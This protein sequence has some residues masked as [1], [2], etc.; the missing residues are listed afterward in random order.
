MYVGTC[1]GFRLGSLVGCG[2]MSSFDPAVP[3]LAVDLRELDRGAPPA[4]PWYQ[5]GVIHD[6]DRQLQVVTDSALHVAFIPVSGGYVFYHSGRGP[7]YPNGTARSELIDHDGRP[8]REL[9]GIPSVSTAGATLAWNEARGTDGVVF[10]VDAISGEV[11]STVALRGYPVGFLRDLVVVQTQLDAR[12]WNPATGDVSSFGA[13]SARHTDGV[14]LIAVEPAGSCEPVL[15]AD[16]GFA[17]AWRRCDLRP[18]TFASASGSGYAL[19][20]LIE[21]DNS[22][23]TFTI[24]DTGTGH[25]LLHIRNLDVDSLQVEPGGN[26]LLHAID[27]ANNL[28]GIIR[29]SLDGDCEL[30]SGLHRVIHPHIDGA[31]YPG[32][33]LPHR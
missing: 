13:Q 22:R 2:A 31:I 19:T 30:A 20:A 29:C 33:K 15:D 12:I 16:Q 11:T 26:L 6:G 24:I 18:P 23:P 32:A 17:P 28:Q 9:L 7:H 5:D 8:K 1:S 25:D 21:A 14:H 3:Q 10:T 27:I 4:V